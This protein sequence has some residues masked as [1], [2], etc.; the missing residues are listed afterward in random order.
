MWK[1]VNSGTLGIISNVCKLRGGTPVLLRPVGTLQD[2]AWLDS[3]K[4][5]SSS[6]K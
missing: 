2:V 1:P 5:N 3:G 4:N 6:I